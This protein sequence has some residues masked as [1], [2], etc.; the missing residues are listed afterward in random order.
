[1]TCF[2]FYDLH[3]VSCSTCSISTECYEAKIRIKNFKNINFNTIQ[4]CKCLGYYNLYNYLCITCIYREL[5]YEIKQGE[6]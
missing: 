4:R 5:C 6:I 2:G 3:N 1:M